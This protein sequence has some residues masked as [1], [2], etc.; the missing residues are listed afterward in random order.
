MKEYLEE[1]KRS[2]NVMKNKGVILYP[3]DTIWGIGCDA[4]CAEA[5]KKIFELKKRTTDKN[6]ILLLD[7]ESRIQ[8]YVK[9]VP[10]QAWS[11][12]EYAEKP[13]TIIYEGAKNLPMEVISE[14]GSIAIRITRDEFCKNLI[15][16]LRK[17]VISTSANISGRPAPASFIDIDEEIIEG[18][19][20]V[21]NWR[22]NEKIIS[23]P[24]T[25]IRLGAGGTIKFI[26]P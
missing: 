11:L 9:E 10:E 16:A 3:T 17:P 2:V 22:Q 23:K 5:V 1:V 12:I 25:I 13:L 14:D 15:G 19:D 24:S 8:S 6:F 7:H 4:T 18:V 26:R 21:A 20:Y